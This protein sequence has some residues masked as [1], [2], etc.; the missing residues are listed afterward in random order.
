MDYLSQAESDLRRYEERLLD[1]MTSQVPFIDASTVRRLTPM[2]AL[3]DALRN[4][5]AEHQA[6]CGTV[7]QAIPLRNAVTM[8]V[9]PSHGPLAAGVKI[10]TVNPGRRPAVTGTYLLIDAGDGRL[11]AIIDA[12]MLTPRRTAAASALACHY[13]AR[14]DAKRLVVIGTGTLSHH[15]VE[16]HASVRNLEQVMVWGRD[17]SKAAKVASELQDAGYPALP[18]TCLEGAVREADI[19]SAATLSKEALVHGAWLNPGVHLDLIGAFTPE[20]CEADPACF[21]RARVFV[22]T[23]EGVM[24]EAGDLLQAI[25]AGVFSEE[26]VVGDLAALCSGRV[27]GR[28]E[29][30][31]IT[32]F[33]SVGTS[34]EDLVA[35]Q[36]IYQ[37]HRDA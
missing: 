37:G 22:D 13:L 5:F 17:A 24:E 30:D 15:L 26:A 14:P 18:V 25:E 1:G 34:L 16:A 11:L 3:I 9:M 20:M 27:S 33:K 35:A 12:V 28:I 2:P 6:G 8:L 36:L 4:A 31:A 7:R 19:I 10:V 21:S 23:R 32:L 29:E